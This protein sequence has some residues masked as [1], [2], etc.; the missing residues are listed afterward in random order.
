MNSASCT[1]DRLPWVGHEKAELN[2]RR[3]GHRSDLNAQYKGLCNNDVGARLLYGDDLPNRI[4]AIGETNHL[5]SKLATP[6]G[7]VSSYTQRGRFGYR[8]QPY[9]TRGIAMWAGRFRSSFLE[10]GARHSHRGKSST[11]QG[12]HARTSSARADYKRKDM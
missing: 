6:S 10:R 9:S 5:S 1:R 11:Q 8:P 4:K 12:K 7:G 2:F 3:D